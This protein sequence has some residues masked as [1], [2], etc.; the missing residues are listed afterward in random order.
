MQKKIISTV[1]IIYPLLILVLKISLNLRNYS[2][3]VKIY[4]ETELKQIN[5][6]VLFKTEKT[7][8]QRKY[9]IQLLK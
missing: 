1:I 7:L 6:E 3:L 9:H 5:R 4:L 2:V 8:N